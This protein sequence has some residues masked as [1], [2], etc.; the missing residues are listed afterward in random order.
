MDAIVTAGA[1]LVMYTKPGCHLCEDMLDVV[2]RALRG[3]SAGVEERNITLD[4]DDYHRYKHD[5]PVLLVDGREVAR[6]RV[7]DETLAVALR[8]AGI[9]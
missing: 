8:T 9:L 3:T 4:L 1:R 7:T 6:H 5:I 2:R